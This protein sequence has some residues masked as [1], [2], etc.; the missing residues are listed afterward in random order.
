MVGVS[1][2]YADK[3]LFLS[4]GTILLE[5]PTKVNSASK[6][7]MPK[8]L[9]SGHNEP[10]IMKECEIVDKKGSREAVDVHFDLVA[11]VTSVKVF[12]SNLDGHLI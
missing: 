9:S 11:A 4:F 5:P 7:R 1:P 3:R 12:A 6:L 8:T 2:S 10:I